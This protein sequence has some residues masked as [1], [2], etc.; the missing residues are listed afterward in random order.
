MFVDDSDDEQAT[1]CISFPSQFVSSD[2]IAINS[3]RTP[4]PTVQHGQG[5]APYL[6]SCTTYV[7]SASQECRDQQR[8]TSA[9]YHMP[10]PWPKRRD[11]ETRPMCS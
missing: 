9:Q 8:A 2:E 10:A 4:V 6:I 5:D 1:V 11:D 7:S 3:N